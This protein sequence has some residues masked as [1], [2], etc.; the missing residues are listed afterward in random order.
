M[1]S[2]P[3]L[4][5]ESKPPAPSDAAFEYGSNLV[6]LAA[7]I[8]A[9][10]L[11]SKLPA[12]NMILICPA[13]YIAI[14]VHEAGHLIA[15]KLN[16]MSA[17]G[18]AI[19]G[20]QFFRSGNR[21]VFHFDRRQ[22]WGGGAMSLAERPD[23]GVGAF[24]WLVAGGPIASGWLTAIC[25]IAL[26]SFGTRTWDWLGSLFWASAIVALVS[27]IPFSYGSN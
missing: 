7:V 11:R 26:I 10:N 1:S 5:L 21:W 17:G 20:F 24:A 18:V 25:T 8:A 3:I 16:G 12:A 27:L 22:L 4:D 6:F 13:F 2:T 23:V 15:G 9:A 14:A 19:G